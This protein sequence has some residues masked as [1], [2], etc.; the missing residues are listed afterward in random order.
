MVS[1]AAD[2]ATT[3]TPTLAQQAAH[4]RAGLFWK[5]AALLF[6]Q[7]ADSLPADPHGNVTADERSLRRDAHLCLNRTAEFQK[8]RERQR[9]RSKHHHFREDWHQPT[10]DLVREVLGSKTCASIEGSMQPRVS[11]VAA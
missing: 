10:G 7:A 2:E 4:M 5:R 6:T 3:R 9:V 8:H 1:H 11:E